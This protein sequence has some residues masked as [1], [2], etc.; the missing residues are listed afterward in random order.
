[1]SAAPKQP[2]SGAQSGRDETLFISDLHLSPQRPE[3]VRLFLDFLGVRARQAGQLYILGDLFDSWIGDDDGTPPYPEIRAALAELTASG[4]A[5][6]L[7]HGNRDFLIG[8]GFSKETRCSL[9]RD[10]TRVVFDGEPTLLMHGDLLC[11]DD[12]AYQRFRRRIR[13]PLVKR[14]FLWKSLSSRRQVAADYRSKSGTATAAKPAQIMDVNGDTV[15]D[16]LR[17]HQASRLIHG[18]THRPAEHPLL[19]DGKPAHRSVLAEWH[20]THGE[21]LVH[22]PGDWHREA[23]LPRLDTD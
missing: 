1:M 18:H 22:T 20:P 2:A 4:T 17:H 8:K 16:Y 10:P 5:C 12:L 7:M 21:A 19:V 6:A 13:N 9:L 3:T 23:I 14:L 15:Q 11:T